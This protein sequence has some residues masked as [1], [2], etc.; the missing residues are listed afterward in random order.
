MIKIS[1][2]LRKSNTELGSLEYITIGSPKID[3][4]REFGWNSY[5]CEVYF[6]DIKYNHPP[7]YGTNPIDPLC[8]ASEIVKIYFQGLVS[9]GYIIS[10]V[11]SR[12]VWK[13]E[14]GKTLSEQ[15][16][17]IK[18]NKDISAEG[19]QKILGIL[20]DTFGKLPHMK[21]QINKFI[22]EEKTLLKE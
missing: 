5:S 19:K 7:I 22:E 10:E 11:E 15:I 12:E 13:L 8:L 9:R 21:D 14:K 17:E 3:K 18:N 4:V 20:K 2:W 6:S 16:S 1:F